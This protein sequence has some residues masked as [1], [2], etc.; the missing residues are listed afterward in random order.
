MPSE[1]ILEFMV[2][3]LKGTTDPSL[4]TLYEAAKR[5]L[6]DDTHSAPSAPQH[7]PPATCGCD[8]HP[9]TWSRGKNEAWICSATLP[10]SVQAWGNGPT[11]EE[12]LAVLNANIAIAKQ[13]MK[14]LG[15]ALPLP[16][17]N[18]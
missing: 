11:P 15:R 14:E 3:G 16:P 6:E 17:T 5:M 2:Q 12:A 13:Q 1:S 9:V 8:S 18:Q 10:G 7:F 4:K